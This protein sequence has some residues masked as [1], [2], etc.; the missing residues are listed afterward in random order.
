MSGE[1]K[2]VKGVIRG[3]RGNAAQGRCPRQCRSALKNIER[4]ISLVRI[5]KAKRQVPTKMG[6]TYGSVAL[7]APGKLTVCPVWE[8]PPV[9]LICAQPIFEKGISISTET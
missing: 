9:T 1:M 8:P 2:E 7:Y 4:T 5:N 3:K 6:S